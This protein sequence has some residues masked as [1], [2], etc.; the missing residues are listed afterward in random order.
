MRLPDGKYMHVNS[1]GAGITY[2]IWRSD[3]RPITLR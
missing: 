3:D 1:Q 2:A